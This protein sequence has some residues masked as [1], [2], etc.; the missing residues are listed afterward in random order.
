[1]SL[2]V[3]LLNSP[4]RPSW[5]VHGIKPRRM[6]GSKPNET[7]RNED[8]VC[9][10]GELAPLV[11]ARR[12]DGRTSPALPNSSSLIGDN[13]V[14]TEITGCSHRLYSPASHVSPPLAEI[15]RRIAKLQVKRDKIK[16]EMEKKISRVDILKAEKI[17]KRRTKKLAEK[18]GD[19]RAPDEDRKKEKPVALETAFMRFG[20]SDKHDKINAGR[21]ETGLKS[22]GSAWFGNRK[23]SLSLFG[24]YDGDPRDGWIDFHEFKHFAQEVSLAEVKDAESGE[25]IRLCVDAKKLKDLIDRL[26][27][28]E[29]SGLSRHW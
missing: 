21:F 19:W 1:M 9:D 2:L 7:K 25:V 29:I 12:I 24:R 15:D 14:T 11:F 3:S 4:V 17:S 26:R 27:R 20:A 22:L 10:D 6:T 8:D 23:E 18:I 28:A 5:I 13:T 16:A